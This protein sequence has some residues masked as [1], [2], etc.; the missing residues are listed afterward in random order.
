MVELFKMMK[1]I[2]KD[3]QLVN[4]L[5]LL[6][7]NTLSYTVSSITDI[8]TSIFMVGGFNGWSNDGDNP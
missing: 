5:L 2:L 6:I 1:I 8:P 7:Y 4:M 3:L